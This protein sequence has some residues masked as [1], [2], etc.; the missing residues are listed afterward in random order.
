MGDCV[1]YLRTHHG[2][3][4]EVLPHPPCFF[5]TYREDKSASASQLDWIR[6]S[7][8]SGRLHMP[9]YLTLFCWLARAPLFNSAFTHSM[10]P[11]DNAHISAVCP[12]YKRVVNNCMV[13]GPEIFHVNP[14]IAEEISI[15]IIFSISLVRCRRPIVTDI[16]WISCR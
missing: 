2:C 11:P 5:V 1:R 12:Y 14:N 16:N 13:I 9:W 3:L 7:Q 6:N 8:Q 10:L 4:C 15:Y